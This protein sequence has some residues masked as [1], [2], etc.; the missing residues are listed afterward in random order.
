MNDDEAIQAAKDLK[1]YLS[2]EL[3]IT[4]VDLSEHSEHREKEDALLHLVLEL[5]LNA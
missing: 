2:N 4:C 3:K 1:V 5:W